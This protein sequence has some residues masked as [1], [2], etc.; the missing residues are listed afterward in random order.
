MYLYLLKYNNFVNRIV[1]GEADLNAYL[2]FPYRV[3]KKNFEMRDGIDTSIDIKWDADF[4]PDYLLVIDEDNANEITSKWFITDMINTSG[5]NYICPLHRDVMVDNYDSIINS[6][7]F[8][9]KGWVSNDN[10]LIYNKEDFSCNQ[11]K[12]SE[13]LLPDYS[14]CS[15]LVLYF[16]AK[17]I[18]DNKLQGSITTNEESYIDLQ[19]PSITD[20]DMITKYGANGYKAPFLKSASIYIDAK[21][22]TDECLTMIEPRSDGLFVWSKE[23]NN[24]ISNQSELEYTGANGVAAAGEAAKTCVMSNE[25]NILSQINALG[26]ESDSLDSLMSF[27]GKLVKAGNN[28]YRVS[29]VQSG[30]GQDYN[31]LTTGALYSA[32][33]NAFKSGG[34]FKSGWT[35]S[36][37]KALYTNVQYKRYN[38]QYVEETNGVVQYQYD[39]SVTADG[40]TVT[41]LDDQPFGI[42]ALPYTTAFGGRPGFDNAGFTPIPVGLN[43]LIARDLCEKGFGPDKYIIDAQIL[44]YC[45]CPNLD[46]IEIGNGDVQ[47]NLTSYLEQNEYNFGVTDGNNQLCGFALMPRKSKFT[48]N[49]FLDIPQPDNLKIANQCDIYRLVSPNYNGQFEFSVAKNRG[50]DYVNIDCTYKPYQP[51]IHLNPNFKGLYGQDFDD[52][53]GLIC[54]GDFSMTVVTSA[55][56]NYKLQNKNYQ[57][58]FNRQIENMD[59]MYEIQRSE[60][61]WGAVAGGIQGA[62]TGAMTGAMVGG[63]WGAAAG[64]I[65]GGAASA[66]G[67]I[68]DYQ[69][70]EKRY[71]ESRNLAIDMHNYQLQNIK[72]LPNSLAKVDAYNN[73]NKI[74]PVLEY[75]TCTDEEKIVFENKLKYEGMTVNAVGYIRNYIN[76]D[77][78]TYIKGQFYRLDDF[79]EDYHVA[80]VICDE[81]SKGV[82]I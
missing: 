43:L 8:I 26:Q 76:L 42:I 6:P 11:I 25:N 72:A 7:C 36:F 57:E 28:Y 10:P 23:M 58:I 56:E 59:T 79:T 1:K 21:G 2:Q 67:G 70:M 45:P 44:P 16:N 48:N 60:A 27:N 71:T 3:V 64:A 61:I 13:R 53:R 55:W 14:F 24:D 68:M 51:Y 34:V 18:A 49:I 32:I 33:T 41:L 66:M 74:F 52:P 82:Y 40:N 69:N 54:G 19:V 38:I 39:F 30:M 15:W 4:K 73:N 47:L 22:T 37:N 12:T 65:V 50:L 81:L 17:A 46:G 5:K 63:G 78:F 62:T 75:Y 9:Q 20:W 35:G 77:D 80:N 29:I 31:E